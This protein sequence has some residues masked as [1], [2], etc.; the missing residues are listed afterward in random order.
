MNTRL[1]VLSHHALAHV[2][3]IV[4]TTHSDHTCVASP[5][6]SMRSTSC[7]RFLSQDSV[8]EKFS[9][10][11]TRGLIHDAKYW[12]IH[13]RRWLYAGTY[14]HKFK[15]LAADK[16]LRTPA[17]RGCHECE[18]IFPILISRRY[19]PL[20]SQTMAALFRYSARSHPWSSIGAG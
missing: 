4:F 18:C 6:T 2:S 5:L 20:A 12:Y 17:I 1:E 15:E 7:D 14:Q 11:K 16:W 10:V 3:F 19:L 8:L 9:R 13:R